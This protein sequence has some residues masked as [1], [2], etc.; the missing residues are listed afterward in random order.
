MSYKY[1]AA[2]SISHIMSW[3]LKNNLTKTLNGL[4]NFKRNCVYMLYLFS[5]LVSLTK[6]IILGKFELL[7]EAYKPL[8]NTWD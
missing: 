2:K 1:Y 6:Q 7:K 5:L 8:F 4:F 3:L